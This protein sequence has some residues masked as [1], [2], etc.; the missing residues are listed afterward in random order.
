MRRILQACCLT[1]LVTAAAADAQDGV[2][3]RLDPAKLRAPAFHFQPEYTF[4]VPSDPQRWTLQPRGLNVSFASTDQAYFRS[5]VPDLQPAQTWKATGWKGERLN[6]EIVVWSPDTVNQVRVAVSD[7]RSASGAILARSNVH[8]SLVRYVVS[9]YPYGANDV[10]CGATD[11]NPPYLMPDRLEPFDRF[12]LPPNSVR[13]IWVSVDIPALATPGVY[14]GTIEV[15]S[16]NGH[17]TLQTQITVQH[18]TLPPPTA[19]EF[20][21]DLW[22]NPWVVAWYYHVEPWSPEHK[23]LLRRHLK[24]YAD[25]GGKYITT[26]AVHSPWSDNSYMIEGAMIEWTK[27]VNGTWKFDYNI[28]DQYVELATSVGVTKA[29][30]I[31]TPLPWG[32]RFRYLDERTGNYVYETWAPDS[33][34][35]ASV[36]RVFLDDLKRHLEQRSWFNRTYLGINENE[37]P[38]TLAAIRVIRA[39]SPKWKITYAGN[40]HAELD[41]LLDDYSPIITAE[42][43]QPELKARSARGR[44]T[45]YYVC[46]TPQ[47]PN[48]F[49]FSPPIEGRYIG[50]Y[51][52]AYGYDGFLRWAYDAW[53]ADPVR[54]ARHALWPAGDEFLVYPGGASS[55]RFE[56]LREGIVDYEKI[57]ILRARASQSTNRE[58]RRQLRELDDHLRTFVG[59][60]DY[61]KRTYD[62]TR[63]TEAVRKGLRMLEALSDRLG[64]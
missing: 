56:K 62:Q 37:M 12:D 32:N 7:L 41:S 55:V 22:Q 4:D 50:W 29:I 27:R 24:L 40:W 19:W 63:I 46:C 33:A 35:F 48:T 30:T 18:Q 47:K 5:E 49:V 39:H 2:R 31:Y 45:T 20:R 11:S 15:S 58:I 53:P 38:F 21:L 52:A 26:Y 23:Q 14:R 61:S 16:E 3:A 57:K 10:S 43:S 54:D 6:T 13:P 9:N 60:P 17:T 25:A 51:A 36:W 8:V 64:R 34:Q 59:D 42:P 28:F 44:S 1:Y